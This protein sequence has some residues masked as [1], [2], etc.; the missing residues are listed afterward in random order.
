[1]NRSRMWLLTLLFGLG[2]LPSTLWVGVASA[3]Q[4]TYVLGV[5]GSAGCLVRTNWEFPPCGLVKRSN[6]STITPACGG[7]PLNPNHIAGQQD[8]KR[9]FAL[10]CSGPLASD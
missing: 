5:G 8:F 10:H 4:T 9:G 1:M 3:D 6:R 7:N 2:V